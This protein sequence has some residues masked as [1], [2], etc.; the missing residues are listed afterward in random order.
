[1]R[2]H[3][4]HTHQH[5]DIESHWYLAVR[6]V[7]MR[8]SYPSLTFPNHY[9]PVTGL[10]L[11]RHGIAHNSMSDSILGKF[12]TADRSAVET[13][14]WWGGV[15]VWVSV[16]RAGLRSATMFWPGSEAAIDGVHPWQWRHYAENTRAINSVQQVRCSAALSKP[17][18]TVHH[19][20][21]GSGG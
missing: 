7:G 20:V 1:M 8:P 13:G 14:D 16:Q 6:A 3:R 5:A 17:T 10:R 19:H 18:A 21:P 9:A 2:S 11:D 4:Y 12:R 15:P